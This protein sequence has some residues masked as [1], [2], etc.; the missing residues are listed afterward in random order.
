MTS[1]KNNKLVLNTF[2]GELTNFID[3]LCNL[4]PESKEVQQNKTYFISCKKVNP[5]AIIIS[6]HTDV[7]EYFK[8]PIEEGDIVFFASHDYKNDPNLKS[9]S[10]FILKMLE[11]LK[12]NVVNLKEHDRETAMKYIQNIS[13]ISKLYIF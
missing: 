2:L 13:K 11:N 3:L 10:P 4:L 12:H 9:Y 5:R 8:K 7:A 6:W 1:T